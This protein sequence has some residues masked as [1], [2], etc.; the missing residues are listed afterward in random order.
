MR[1]KNVRDSHRDM[2]GKVVAA[3][4]SVTERSD[5]RSWVMIATP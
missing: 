1:N 2:E 5:K 4:D 3:G